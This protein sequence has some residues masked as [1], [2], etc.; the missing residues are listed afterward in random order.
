MKK[1]SSSKSK[2][3]PQPY[4]VVRASA[5]GVH[6]GYLVSRDGDSVELRNARRLFRWVVAKM[7]GQLS[8]LSEVAVYGLNTKDDRSRIGVAV[9]EHR[10]IGVCEILVVNALAQQSIE[11]AP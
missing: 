3:K 8:S 9:P 10:I 11:G 6:A 2:S 1:T 4:V 5:A 7:S